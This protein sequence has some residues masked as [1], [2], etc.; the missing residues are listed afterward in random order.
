[1]LKVIES[2]G[3]EIEST[4]SLSE[5]FE[6]RFPLSLAKVLG[7]AVSVSGIKTPVAEHKCM[8]SER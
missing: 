3:C 6:L 8:P 2:A 4:V 1:V 5:P 7:Y